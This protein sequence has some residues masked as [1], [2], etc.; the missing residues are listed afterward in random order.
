MVKRKEAAEKPG[1][2]ESPEESS[3]DEESSGDEVRQ[4]FYIM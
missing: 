4:R 1:E 2:E 3:S